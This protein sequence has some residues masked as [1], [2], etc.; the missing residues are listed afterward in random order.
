[1]EYT[2]KEE[3]HEETDPSPDPRCEEGKNTPAAPQSDLRRCLKNLVGWLRVFLQWITLM[4]RNIMEYQIP[5]LTHAVRKERT[6]QHEH[7]EET[8]PSPDPRC[9]EGKN[10]PAAPQFDQPST[11]VQNKVDQVRGKSESLPSDPPTAE[12]ES[13]NA[14]WCSEVGTLQEKADGTL[15]KPTAPSAPKEPSTPVQNKVDQ[16]SRESEALPSDPPAAEV[17]SNN[18]TWCSE[19]GTLQEK[20]DGTLR[21]PTAPS[22]P[23]EP[24][25]PVQNKV[26]QVS[27][28]SEA[29]PS[30]PPAAEV[31]SNNATWCSEGETLHE[32]ADG[33]LRKPTAPSAPKEKQLEKFLEELGLDH[34]YREKLSLSTLLRIDKKTKILNKLL[35]NSQQYHDTFV[36]RNM[37][38]G[39]SPR[40]ISNGLVEMAWYLPCGNKNMDVFSEP[41]AVANLRGDIA[42]FETQF[43]FLCQTSAA[44]FV[45]FDALDSECELLTNQQHKAQIFLVGNRQ[46]KDFK[47]DAVK[48]VATKLSLTKSNILLKDKH[49]N[50]ANFVKDLREKVSNAFEN[51]KVTRGIE[52]MADIAHE[53][54]VCVD[55]DSPDCQTAKTNA[56]AITAE[57]HDILQY[58]EAQLPLQG[59][60]WKDLTC[61]E[62]EELRLREVGSESIEEYKSRLHLKKIELRKKQNSHDMSKAMT[63]FINA[64]SSPGIER[65]YFLK[66]MR[67]NLDN[68]SREKL[69]DLR[70]Q[71]KEKCRNSENKKEIKEIEEKL[72]NSSLGTEHF[73]REMGQ[74]YEASLSLLETDPAQMMKDKMQRKSKYRDTYIEEILK[75]IDE[76]LQHNQEV[77]ITFEVS[78]KLHICG[79]AARRFQKM[80]EDFIH[81]NDPYRCLNKNKER[82]RSDF[83]DVFHHVD[84]CQK[85]ADEFTDRCLKPAVEDFVNRS[86]GPDIIGEMRTSQQF[87][88]RMF[89]QYSILLDL[90]SEDD[91]KKYQS[92]ICSYEKYV[93]NW[94]LNKIVERFSNGSTMFEEQHLQSRVNSINNAIQKAQTEKS[95]NLKSF[96]KVVC[97][98]LGD[99]L[100]ISQDA[101]GKF[102]ILNN[103][104]QEQFAHRLTEC[105]KEM[106]QALREKFKETNI[107]TKLQ[108][109]Q[110]KPQNVLFN[111]LIG[112]GKQCPFCNAPCDAGARDHKEHFT[113]LHR[114]QGLGRS[115]WNETQILMIDL[116]SSSVNSD[117]RFRCGANDEWHPYKSYREMYPD[118]NIPADASFQASDYWKYVM[119]KFNDEFAG[120]FDAKPADIP[121]GWKE[122]KKE[123][124]KASL[125]ESFSIK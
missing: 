96:V 97:Q 105:V 101:L 71:Y 32:K 122:I 44:V 120:A 49:I 43:A 1:M 19:V 10:T 124:A 24:S 50:D 13:N 79:D 25:T 5:S 115:R 46:S 53:H 6:L 39:D 18:A 83:K 102:M 77:D 51:T 103:A 90:L 9:E 121:P 34:H 88:S 52:K 116:C 109:L 85:K 47:S 86:L 42:S 30:D 67:M 3:H 29:L 45:F 65:C 73:F 106:A 75:M 27:R 62:K 119:A 15:R 98:E 48:T 123:H 72:S 76:R 11:P 66:W 41:V 16:V 92:C 104:N 68:V 37:E 33:T 38:G 114:P 113:L 28:E 56:D 112:C 12:V 81:E 2:D 21:K 55:E 69:F 95:G 60:I 94:I 107:Q 59:Q 100:V 35:S 89:F 20:A 74:I 111:T 80:H 78:L 63:C 17:E 61:L 64:I 93:K 7:H 31:E 8:D 118:W 125:K 58:K 117:N 84:Q 54:G 4:W 82:F 14:T 36:H 22:A 110:V 23:K 87:S 108:N 26:D 40:K 70:E 91:F 57:I 99:K